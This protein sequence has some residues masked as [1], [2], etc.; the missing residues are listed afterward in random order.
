[1]SICASCLRLLRGRGKPSAADGGVVRRSLSA[2]GGCAG[3]LRPGISP[4]GPAGKLAATSAFRRSDG[5]ICAARGLASQALRMGA[6]S[7]CAGTASARGGGRR[8]FAA[9]T[10]REGAGRRIFGNRGGL[11]SFPAFFQIAKSRS[12]VFRDASYFSE[13]GKGPAHHLRSGESAACTREPCLPQ[14]AAPQGPCVASRRAWPRRGS[15]L[16]CLKGM[17]AIMHRY[18]LFCR[19]RRYFACNE[20]FWENR[21]YGNNRRQDV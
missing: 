14:H 8:I 19:R 2:R 13:R 16:P 7:E 17:A 11:F 9:P 10:L 15:F 20:S 1:M 18:L 12:G 21:R 5:R 3:A 4:R 6:A